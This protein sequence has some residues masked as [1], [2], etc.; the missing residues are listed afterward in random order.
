MV[1]FSA[2]ASRVRLLQIGG[3]TMRR[4]QLPRRGIARR[5]LLLAL[6][7]LL[8]T[9]A[10]GCS[11]FGAQQAT[12]PNAL[13]EFPIPTA[14]SSPRGIVTGPGGNLWFAESDGNKIGRITP[15]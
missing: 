15:A 2:M 5:F 6:T 10:S 8:V 11:G 12:L 1:R 14:N 3:F 13:T 4:E 7:G 9:F